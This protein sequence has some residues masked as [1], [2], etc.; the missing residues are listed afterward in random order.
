MS[1]TGS[2]STLR[3]GSQHPQYLHGLAADF[4]GI[5]LDVLAT[6]KGDDARDVLERQEAEFKTL[7][8]CSSKES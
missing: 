6:P 5:S 4:S 1:N 7:Y 2:K 3:G 8:P